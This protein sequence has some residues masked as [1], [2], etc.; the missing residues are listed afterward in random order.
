MT[1]QEKDDVGKQANNFAKYT[2]MAFQMLAT[3][4]LFTFIGYKIDERQ[5]HNKAIYAALFGFLGVVVSL[6]WVI[7]SLTKKRN[8]NK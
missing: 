5:P 2:G 8:L 7:R 6:Y 4:G 1:D 3:I